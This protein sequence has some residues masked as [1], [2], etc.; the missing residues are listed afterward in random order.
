MEGSRARCHDGKDRRVGTGG[1]G[2][3]GDRG[4]Q[5][6]GEEAAEPV[7]QVIGEREEPQSR[8]KLLAKPPLREELAELCLFPIRVEASTLGSRS[9]ALGAVRLA[10]DE[11]ERALLAAADPHEYSQSE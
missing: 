5:Q 9:V 6:T 7:S 4:D 2:E 10:L 11:V 3:H 1:S 8:A